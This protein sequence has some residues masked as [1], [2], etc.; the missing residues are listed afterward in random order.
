MTI[1]DERLAEMVGAGVPCV[2]AH[3]GEIAAV[4]QEL[5][6][7]RAAAAK[8]FAYTTKLC[9]DLM[10]EKPGHNG[11]FSLFL[12]FEGMDEIKGVE[13]VPLYLKSEISK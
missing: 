13:F 12:P 3:P 8:P 1:S 7:A 11:S 10:R 4:V 9:L 6:K 5:R 2:P